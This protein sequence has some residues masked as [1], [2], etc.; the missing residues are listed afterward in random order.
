MPSSA[1]VELQMRERWNG[2]V[3]FQD[4]ELEEQ[5]SYTMPESLWKEL[6]SPTGLRVRLEDSWNDP[7]R[8]W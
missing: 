2:I 7:E 4:K 6:G 1:V 8:K 5:L 3:K